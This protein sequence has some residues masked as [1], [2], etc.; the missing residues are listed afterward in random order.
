LGF[1]IWMADG[2]ALSDRFGGKPKPISALGVIG[3]RYPPLARCKWHAVARRDDLPTVCRGPACGKFCGGK[4][5]V[6]GAL[7]ASVPG[8]AR[9][10]DALAIASIATE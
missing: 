4:W 3:R 6:V 1:W 9:C 5:M 8:V 2:Q 10:C 7:G